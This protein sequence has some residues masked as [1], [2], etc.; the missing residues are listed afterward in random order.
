[1]GQ[2]IKFIH[3]SDIH[4][5]PATKKNINGMGINTLHKFNALLNDIRKRALHPD[6]FIISGDLIH[7]GT[8]ED[9]R[10]L[11]VLLK[12]QE[13]AF[14]VPFYVCLG[15]HD[16]RE[17]F[18]AGYK[19]VPGK[20]EAY[21]YSE[22]VNDLKLIFLDSKYGISEEEG[23][24]SGEQ[25]SW[26]KE[27][28]V[29]TPPGGTILILHHPLYCEPLDFMKYSI[30]QNTDELVPVIEGKDILAIL[31]GHIHFNATFKTAGIMNF[32]IAA[33]SYG[34]DCSNHRIH[35]FMDDSTYGLV[36]IVDREVMVEQWSLPAS[37]NVKFELSL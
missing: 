17:A 5:N 21:Y 20:K 12:E 35:K 19:N 37:K 15:N 32:V 16:D 9:Y 36:R 10:Q 23:R 6:F 25:L 30:L 27:Q 34:I 13:K 11:H 3:L 1:M 4:L 29:V 22:T 8:V 31:S 2:K 24:I 14:G 28:L 7:E 26:L 33:A 18:W